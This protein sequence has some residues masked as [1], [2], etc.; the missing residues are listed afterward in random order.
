[1]INFDT[2]LPKLISTIESSDFIKVEKA[3]IVRDLRG[4]L[5][6]VL[7]ASDDYDI[8]AI[9]ATLETKLGKWF[10]GPVLNAKAGS[11]GQKRLAKS[12]LSS[13]LEWPSS[14][15]KTRDDGTG[16]RIDIGD[17]WIGKQ[18]LL[19]KE[20][21]L[22]SPSEDDIWPLKSQ[23]PTIVA[24]YSFKG[25][26]GRSTLLGMTAYK[27]AKEGKK[28]VCIDLDLEAPGLNGFFGVQS[29]TS[30]LDALL[31]HAVTDSLPATG[32]LAA[33]DVNYG[34]VEV[35]FQAITAGEMN[36]RYVEK[37]ARLDYLSSAN[38][39]SPVAKALNALLKKIKRDENPDYILLDCRAGIHDL[40]GLS[41]VQFAHIDV[42]VGRDSP[43]GR[44]GLTLTLEM[45]GKAK[46]SDRQ[47][48]QIVQTFVPTEK[49]AAETSTARFR[50]SMHDVCKKYLYDDDDNVPELDNDSSAHFPR[51]L[52]EDKSISASETLQDLP[53]N[54]LN[55]AGLSGVCEKIEML[56]TP[57]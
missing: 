48:L 45:L 13:S 49:D 30:V 28:V 11:P 32:L 44:E 20:S 31:T 8:S 10:F 2:A 4:R 56:S 21:W 38:E 57:S 6:L 17:R 1:M 47:R 54:V 52:T 3:C 55:S 41:L 33:V 35:S 27:M 43:Q 16:G 29:E 15:P 40:G 22:S 9:S 12:I 19:S 24:F 51:T 18:R 25:G 14:W 23:T 42:L 34:D 5:R 50:E 39:A 53:E 36:G 7:E 37:L 26:V 46:K